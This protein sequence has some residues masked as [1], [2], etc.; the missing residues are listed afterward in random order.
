MYTSTL[1]ISYI[2]NINSCVWICICT[3]YMYVYVCINMYI[4]IWTGDLGGDTAYVSTL[5]TIWSLLDAKIATHLCGSTK[6]AIPTLT[7]YVYTCILCTYILYHKLIITIVF[8][9]FH[10]HMLHMWYVHYIYAGIPNSKT[11]CHVPPTNSLSLP[12]FG[13][14]C[15]GQTICHIWLSAME[16]KKTSSL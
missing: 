8:L 3:V 2:Y 12:G 10:L 9:N 14:E 16:K 1:A 15:M 13:R 4:N 6:F 5:S 7:S 11:L